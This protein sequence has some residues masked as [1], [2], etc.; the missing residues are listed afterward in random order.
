MGYVVD[1]SEKDV[2]GDTR[3]GWWGDDV[4]L[5]SCKHTGVPRLYTNRE[6]NP[7]YAYIRVRGGGTWLGLKW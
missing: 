4:T 5:S 2:G 6:G 3:K 1:T 7:V